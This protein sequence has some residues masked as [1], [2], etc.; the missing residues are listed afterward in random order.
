MVLVGSDPCRQI[1]QLL[2]NGHLVVR[3]LFYLCFALGGEKQPSLL[4]SRLLPR[5]DFQ[6]NHLAF[7]EL[8]EVMQAKELPFLALHALKSRRAG[9]AR[10][11]T[12][13]ETRHACAQSMLSQRKTPSRPQL[14]AQ[15]H[16]T[17][18]TQTTHCARGDRTA[19]EARR[20]HL[21]TCV[22][23]FLVRP[24]Q[25]CRRNLLLVHLYATYVHGKNKPTNLGVSNATP[26]N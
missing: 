12:S 19:T 25:Y 8:E 24:I 11:A 1:T 22:Q 13:R 10:S 23:T 3:A 6:R 2:Q 18:T 9:A 26:L 7:G 21:D 5:F 14:A 4:S 17:Q 20:S 16:T 15:A